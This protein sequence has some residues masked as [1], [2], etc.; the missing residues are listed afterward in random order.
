VLALSGEVF[1]MMEL[2]SACLAGGGRA[3]WS[4]LFAEVPS[5]G[6]LCDV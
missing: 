2:Q 3:Q 6:G 4:P 5:P 1:S